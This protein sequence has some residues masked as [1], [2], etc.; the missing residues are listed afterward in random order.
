MNVLIYSPQCDAMGGIETHLT[1]LSCALKSFPSVNDV[2]V[3]TTSNSLAQSAQS[4]MHAAGVVLHCFP[5]PRGMAGKLQKLAWLARQVF[6]LRSVRWDVIYTNGQGGLTSLIWAAA[7]SQT[8]IFHHHHTSADEEDKG[9]WPRLYR[10]AVR[11]APSLIVTS[12]ALIPRFLEV[13][14][15]S[16]PTI[17]LP[18]LLPFAWS[19][20][21]LVYQTGDPIR[22]GY[23]GRLI[24]AKGIDRILALS[25]LPRLAGI[26]WHIWGEGEAYPADCFRGFPTVFYHGAFKGQ[27]GLRNALS[28][29]HGMVLLSQFAEGLPLMLLEGMSAGLPWIAFE[30]GGVAQV[31]LRQPDCQVLS[32]D[33]DLPA[34]ADAV[35]QLASAIQQRITSP[36]DIQ[37][38]FHQ[39]FSPE[40]VSRRWYQLFLT[41]THHE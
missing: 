36:A 3:V 21:P 32:P 7:R 9:S 29:L 14:R 38:M 1:A 30:K 26:E 33:A 35:L 24:P 27:D 40:A 2:H 25:R 18:C 20:D 22:L 28:Q 31:A 17:S 13:R 23:F 15:A 19:G 41:G 37:S 11:L 16:R 8:R 5:V 4:A 6:T 34:V 39:S 12:P 10:A